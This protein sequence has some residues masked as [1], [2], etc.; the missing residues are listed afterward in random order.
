MKSSLFLEHQGKQY[1]DK[2]ILNKAK[3]IWINSGNKLKDI[4]TLNL[5]I[6]PEENA[7]YYVIN[8]NTSGQFSIE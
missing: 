3:E 7:I 8:D 2:T 6:K 4:K 5:Y 1:D